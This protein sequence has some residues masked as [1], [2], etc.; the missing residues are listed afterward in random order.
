MNIYPAIDLI[1]GKCVRLSQG[2]FDNVKVYCED[3]FE[4]AQRFFDMGARYLHIVDLDAA[5]K[6]VF[7]NKEVLKKISKIEGLK[8]ETGGGVRSFADIEE[9]LDIGVD[10]VIIGTKAVTD[11]DFLIKAIK[12]YGAERIVAGLDGRKGFA[13]V[14]GWEKDSTVSI[15]ELAKKYADKGLRYV[16]YTDI[17]RDGML[18]GPDISF[19]KQLVEETGLNIIA[20]GGISSASDV[21]EACRIGCEGTIIGKAY[22]EGKVNLEE[23]LARYNT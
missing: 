2:A 20:S 6:G 16:I 22:Y 8:F 11:P 14:N 3:P 5:R 12:N 21:E 4:M 18:C 23:L 1:D 19:T 10:R 15:L 7:S 9:R 17:S 13:S